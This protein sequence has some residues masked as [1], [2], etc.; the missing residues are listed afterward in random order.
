MDKGDSWTPPQE[1]LAGSLNSRKQ[2]TKARCALDEGLRGSFLLLCVL[3]A[4]AAGCPDVW[5]ACRGVRT[6]C[7]VC[8]CRTP[9]HQDPGRGQAELWVP[10]GRRA[11]QVLLGAEERNLVHTGG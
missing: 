11:D 6:I 4:S 9:G 3:A 1:N 10:E 7:S 8:H 2:L 5:G